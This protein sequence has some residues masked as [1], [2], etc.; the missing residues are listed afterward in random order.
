MGRRLFIA[1]SLSVALSAFGSLSPTYAVSP[2]TYYVAQTGVA[3]LGTG[4]SCASPDAVGLTSVAIQTAVTAS[5]GGDTIHICAGTYTIVA[6]ITLAGPQAG[7]VIEGAGAGLT[8]LNGQNTRTGDVS[9]DDG[10]QI[11]AAASLT[12][13]LHDLDFQAG[14]GTNGGAIE[15]GTLTITGSSFDMNVAT[16][17]GGAISCTTLTIDTSS[18][19]DNLAGG[20]GGA[21]A[22]TTST[23]ATTDFTDNFAGGRGGAIFG[24]T[25]TVNTGVF[26]N[27]SAVGT[28][29][30]IFATTATLTGDDFTANQGA[31][32]TYGLDLTIVGTG[33]VA[34]NHVTL[35]CTVGTCTQSYTLPTVITATPGTVVWSGANSGVCSGVTCS[36]NQV[37]VAD[38]LVTSATTFNNVSNFEITATF[39]TLPSTTKS[40]G[41]DWSNWT[42]I[43]FGLVALTGALG[44]AMRLRKAPH[45]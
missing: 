5:V 15:A 18:F 9:N 3:N 44:V 17:V 12:L 28:G 14:F 2:W 39:P 32:P 27:N 25:T 40:G 21:I 7:L 43:L 11:L 16:G 31:T 36:M 22:C 45:A 23:T 19:T 35:T 41:S 37:V 6:P 30:A 1:L 33:S 29:G 10:Q 4:G 20:D 26:T 8:I 24:T 42:E 38:T 34:D 13:T